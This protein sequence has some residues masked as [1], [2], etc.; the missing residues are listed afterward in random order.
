[1]SPSDD[2]NWENVAKNFQIENEV[3]RDQMKGM[4][5]YDRKHP[6]STVSFGALFK[7]MV[8]WIEAH[9]FAVIAIFYVLS[10]LLMDVVDISM[11]VRKAA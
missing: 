4:L 9:P 11:K 3:L 10:T 1:M 7:D 8:M 5:A 2:V 6:I